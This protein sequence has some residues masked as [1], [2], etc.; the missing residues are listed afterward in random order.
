MHFYL[1]FSFGE[2]VVY[3]NEFYSFQKKYLVSFFKI[4]SEGGRGQ[5]RTVY[6]IRRRTCASESGVK[7][8]DA[9]RQQ[10]FDFAKPTP[11]YI[12][13]TIL[14]SKD[15]RSREQGY[16]FEKKART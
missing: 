10:G 13:L 12:I 2:G 5:W 4:L 3:D 1:F 11:W 16:L 7:R 9:G 14:K 8:V 6:W 15:T